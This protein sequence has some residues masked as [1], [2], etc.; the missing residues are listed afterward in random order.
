MNSPQVW[1]A[2]IGAITAA[3]GSITAVCLAI[4][5]RNN[6]NEK[7]A[8]LTSQVADN[9]ATAAANLE[10]VRRDVNGQT[11]QLLKVQGDARAAIGNL[12]GHEQQKRESA[13]A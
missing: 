11:Q 9:A 3:I 1:I 6:F 7:H 4:I 5:Q 12:K 8:A 2:A 10:I 13:D